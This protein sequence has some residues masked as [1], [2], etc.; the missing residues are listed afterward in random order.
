MADLVR[1]QRWSA[2]PAAMLALVVL[3]AI[4][5]CAEGGSDDD[6]RSSASETS[7]SDALGLIAPVEAPPGSPPVCRGLV[8]IPGLAEVGDAVAELADPVSQSEGARRL[9]EVAQDLRALRESDDI[10]AIE[11]TADAL[12]GAAENGLDENSADALAAELDEL[13][14][15]VQER[16]DFPVG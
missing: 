7:R 9:N 1:R 3:V 11:R 13:G 14:E 4:G 10:D 15:E 2:P 12:E 8:A 16:C 6:S 5:G